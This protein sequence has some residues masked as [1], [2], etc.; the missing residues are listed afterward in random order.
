MKTYNERLNDLATEFAKVECKT[1]GM[2]FDPLL[3]SH[4]HLVKQYLPQASIALKHMAEAYEA[5]YKSAYNDG[6][7]A[8]Y[9]CLIS[10]SKA[11]CGK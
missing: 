5:G 6:D 8:H 7:N 1:R 10:V 2:I 4:L 3:N 9:N 11:R